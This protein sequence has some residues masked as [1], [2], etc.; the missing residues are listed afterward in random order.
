MTATSLDPPT[1][2]LQQGVYRRLLEEGHRFQFVQAVRLLDLAF[3]EK[4]KPIGTPRGDRRRIRLRPSPALVFPAADVSGVH[5]GPEAVHVVQTFLG[6]YGLCSPLPPPFSEDVAEEGRDTTAHRDFL[7]LFNH[8]L[9]A[10]F[11][12]AWKKYRPGL[13]MGD[14][15]GP[16]RRMLCLAG[17]GAR[18]PSSDPPSAPAPGQLA[19]QAALFGAQTP[20]A[21][22]LEALV[23]SQLSDVQVDVIENVPRWI[24]SPTQYGLGDDGLQ[25]GNGGILGRHVYDRTGKFRLRLG[26]LTLD[27]YLALLPGGSAA[28]RVDR[29]VRLY[30]PEALTYDVELRVPSAALPPTRLGAAGSQLG[31]TTHLG[32]P[33]SAM[34]SRVVDYG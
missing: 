7:D 20:N 27:Q 15:A 28:A 26:P 30:V 11:Y 3:P 4:E 14:A 17:V 1:D 22:G 21:E 6:L 33:T 25:L 18:P 8:R 12:R 34:T 13:R 9:L 2:R 24:P 5:L 29:L 23:E 16:H 32:T 19:A 31:R 10:F